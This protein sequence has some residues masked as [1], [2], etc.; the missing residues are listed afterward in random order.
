VL[1]RALPK[2]QVMAAAVAGGTVTVPKAM[3]ALRQL[4]QVEHDLAPG[5]VRKPWHR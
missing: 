4:G 1:G 5:S 2:N 3:T